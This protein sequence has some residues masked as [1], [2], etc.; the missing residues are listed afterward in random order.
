MEING[1]FI[2]DGL[3][4]PQRVTDLE[5]SLQ[6]LEARVTALEQSQPDPEEPEVPTTSEFP[7]AQTTGVPTGTSL[8]YEENSMTI[9]QDG[10]VLDGVHVDGSV[11]IDA[12]NVTIRN[13]LIQTGTSLYPIYV[14]S[15]ATGTVIEDVEIDNRGGTG[16]GMYLQG[17]NVTV[18][19]VN[20][21]SAEDGIRIQSHDTSI[22]DSY[23]HDLQRHE[24]G[25]HDCIQIR[26]GDNVTLRGNNLQAFVPSIGDYM[27]ASIQ[28]GSLSGTNSISNFR[29]IGNLMN[30]GNFTV[31]GGRSGDIDS[32]YYADNRFGRDC[33][34]GVVGNL[35]AGDVWDHTNVWHDTGEPVR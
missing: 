13:C 16:I 7:D 35:H 14:R 10:F 12:D 4:D 23:I 20:I 18:R 19:R 30:G 8:R 9:T 25:H 21:H 34:Y 15:S 3:V 32:A 2:S 31:N 29:V 17:D 28:V 1:R 6:A 27:N 22:E 33:R 26:S 24:G 11:T 5:Q